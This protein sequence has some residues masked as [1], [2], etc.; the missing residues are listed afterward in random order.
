MS[1]FTSEFD[2][3]W[4]DPDLEAEV[5]AKMIDTLT[6]DQLDQAIALF[7]EA[8]ATTVNSTRFDSK[9]FIVDNFKETLNKFSIPFIQPKPFLRDL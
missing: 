5:A 4:Y 2:E 6:E 3:T 8:P 1:E 7:A 9:S